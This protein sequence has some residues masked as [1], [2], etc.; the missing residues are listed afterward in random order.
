MPKLS[1]SFYQNPDVV[2]L[3]QDLLGK[4]L[5]TYIDEYLCSGKIV[6]TEAYQGPEDRGSHAYK[7]R[8]TPR[9]STMYEA[10]GVAYVY[11]CYGIHQLFNVVSSVK[12]IPHA[13][14][15]RAIEPVENIDIMLIRRKKDILNPGLTAG[16]GLLCE[17]LGITKKHNGISLSGNTI[18]LEDHGELIDNEQLIKS[19]RVG[20]NFS[21]PYKN[22]PWRFRIKG[23]RFCS[24]S[25]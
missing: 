21:G 3:A 19:P 9:T 23:N 24:P 6:E 12:S 10:G 8:Y 7:G 25:R 22:I 2:T 20:M 18:W 17:A 1:L 14:L 16:P 15:I 4:F 5:Y 11:T 13:V